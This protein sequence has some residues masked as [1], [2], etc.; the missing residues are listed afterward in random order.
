MAEGNRADNLIAQY[1]EIARHYRTYVQCRSQQLFFWETT[2]GSGKEQKTVRKAVPFTQ[3]WSVLPEPGGLMDQPYRM[4]EFFE[5]FMRAER[6]A[7][8]VSLQK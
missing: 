8:F 1:P 7:T 6:Q 5:I 2:K 4:F 3:G